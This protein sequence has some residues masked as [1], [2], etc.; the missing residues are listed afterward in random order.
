MDFAEIIVLHITRSVFKANVEKNAQKM[1]TV[2]PMK[3]A[4]LKKVFASVVQRFAHKERLVKQEQQEKFV[5]V[6]EPKFARKEP[7]VA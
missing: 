4:T 6:L 1:R 3:F 7:F 2:E 5:S